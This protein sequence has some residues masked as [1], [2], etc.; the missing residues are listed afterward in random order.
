MTTPFFIFLFFLLFF[1]P[2][3]FTY[4]PHCFYNFLLLY[5]TA[6]S[7][8]EI[9]F[10]MRVSFQVKRLKIDSFT[11][12]LCTLSLFLSL[13][14]RHDNFYIHV[15]K[16]HHFTKDITSHEFNPK[17]WLIVSKGNFNYFFNFPSEW[18]RLCLVFNYFVMKFFK[19]FF[20]KKFS[21]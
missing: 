10:I 16:T 6:F 15:W 9:N 21:D 3:P 20:S 19:S 2:F 5:P 8:S 11:L 1:I 12:S 18:K 14:V 4:L 17:S 13:S 7:A